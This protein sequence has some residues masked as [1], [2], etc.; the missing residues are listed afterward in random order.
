MLS[1]FRQIIR[2]GVTVVRFIH[3]QHID[4]WLINSYK[5]PRLEQEAQPSVPKGSVYFLDDVPKTPKRK[6]PLEILESDPEEVTME[7]INSEDLEEHSRLN[8]SEDVDLSENQPRRSS[9][10]TTGL[11]KQIDVDRA[12]QMLDL[13]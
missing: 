2:S 4:P 1:E 5:I 9:R 11:L 6:R 8:I 13:E 7:E 10:K 3:N 12:A